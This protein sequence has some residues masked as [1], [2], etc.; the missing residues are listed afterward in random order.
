[1]RPDETESIWK[2]DGPIGRSKY[3]WDIIKSFL[4]VLPAFFF[5]DLIGVTCKFVA[6]PFTFAVIFIIASFW[7]YFCATSKR[8]YD[9]IGNK[10]DAILVVIGSYILSFIFKPTAL[11]VLLIGLFAK[12]KYVST[13]QVEEIEEKKEMF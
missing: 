2:I 12:G 4:I 6:L 7:I 9:V 8:Y 13:G 1:M 3:F 5:R 11:V 10:R